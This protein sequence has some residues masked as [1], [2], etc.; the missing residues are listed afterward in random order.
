MCSIADSYVG[1]LALQ[2]FAQEAAQVF[3]VSLLAS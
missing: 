1:G 3:V 2:V